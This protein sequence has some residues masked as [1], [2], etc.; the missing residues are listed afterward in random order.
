MMLTEETLVPDTALPVDG[1]KRHLRMGSGFA[2]DDVQDAVLTGFLRAAMAVIEGRTA[3]TLLARDFL[4]SVSRWAAPDA[5]PLGTAPVQTLGSV[6][7]ID[8]HGTSSLVAPTA[9]RLERDAQVP[10]L[11][12][13]ASCLPGIPAGGSAEV[14]FTAGY[15]AE[16]G[17]LPADLAQAVLLLAA[18]YYEYR[19]ETALGEGCMPFGVT[20]L[21]ARYRPVRIGFGA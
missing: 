5:Q 15:V 17:D 14:R 8:R 16:F 18:H 21:L 4:L 1:L 6:T 7:L 10:R 12:S 9:Y 20:A 13:I 3:K 11:R 2:E 19:D